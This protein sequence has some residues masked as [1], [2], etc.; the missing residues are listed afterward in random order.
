MCAQR[1][2]ALSAWYLQYLNDITDVCTKARHEASTP[3]SGGAADL[4]DLEA[5]FDQELG[6]VDPIAAL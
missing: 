1:Y 3:A 5:G 4:T 6:P 2:A